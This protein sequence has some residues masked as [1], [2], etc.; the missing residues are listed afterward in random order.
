VC[1]VFEGIRASGRFFF[2]QR[3]SDP[4]QKKFKRSPNFFVPTESGLF[5][6]LNLRYARPI[7]LQKMCTV[8]AAQFHVGDKI[9]K[10]SS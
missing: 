4:E 5:A 8:L 3:D 7:F 9:K 2:F 1:Q 6:V 10:S